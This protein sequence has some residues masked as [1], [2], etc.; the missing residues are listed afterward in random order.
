MVLGQ[1][2]IDLFYSRAPW[3][4][5]SHCSHAPSANLE[6]AFFSLLA[7]LHSWAWIL[8]YHERLERSS[9]GGQKRSVG[10]AGCG[11]TPTI[12]T[13]RR[14]SQEDCL[15]SSKTH[16][17]KVLHARDRQLMSQHHV[18]V[19]HYTDVHGHS[20]FQWEDWNIQNTFSAS[21]WMP[22]G[23]WKS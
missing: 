6:R 5:C 15:K 2:I 12:L 18:G 22:W 23:P 20:N 13:L 7:H 3:S 19:P 14:Q 11:G 21:P 16:Q 9:L 1:L 17:P 10:A 8:G 4:V